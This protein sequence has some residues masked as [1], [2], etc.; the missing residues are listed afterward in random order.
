MSGEDAAATAWTCLYLPQ[1][2]GRQDFP[3]C[4]TASFRPAPSQRERRCDWE[5][6]HLGFKEGGGMEEEV[7][8]GC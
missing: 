2:G 8:K 3:E 4:H 7:G 6:E 1:E 5:L